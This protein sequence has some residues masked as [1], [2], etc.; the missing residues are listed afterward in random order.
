M[1][2]PVYVCTGFLDSGKT[3]FI[4]D[5]LMKQDWIIDGPTLL[6]R[7][8]EGEVEYSE[9][10]LDENALFLFDI[11]E[12]EK[13]NFTFLSNCE[14]IY[15]PSQVIIEYNGMWD[16]QEILSLKLPEDWEIQGVYSTVNG[17]TL[18]MYFKNMRNLL[19]NQLVESELIVVNRCGEDV[20]RATFRRAIK[21]QN[22]IADVLFEN[23][24]GEMIPMTEE[25]LPY[26]VK[27]DV[28]EIGDM[29]YGI[30]YVDAYEN[31]ERYL[32]KEI[33]FLAQTFRPKGMPDTMFIPGRQIMSCCADDVEFYGYPTKIKKGLSFEQRSWAKVK[34]RFE[35][36]SPRMFSPKQ[37]ILYLLEMEKAEKPEEEVVYLG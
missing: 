23:P 5:T 32:H 21:I 10:Y 7:C 4:K 27:A 9:E 15:H 25:D 11:D 3:T 19:L 22:P 33:S 34:V 35:Y 20:N 13:L 31:P 12:S 18:E 28:I 24:D 36:E 2:T 30:W 14:K 16:L 29:D 17:E 26:D 37:P 1:T 6:L 8:E